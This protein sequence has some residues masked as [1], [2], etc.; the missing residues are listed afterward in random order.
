MDEEE[1][2][3]YGIREYFQ[4]KLKKYFDI[5]SFHTKDAFI[6]FA[7]ERQKEIDV[8][9]GSEELLL[10]EKKIHKVKQCI[11]LSSG[12]RAEQA[13][14]DV[15]YKYQSKECIM[16]EFLECCRFCAGTRVTGL[17]RNTKLLGVYSP[18]G[19]CGKTTLAM[20]LG[21]VL[22]EKQK[23]LYMSFEEW[24][25][26][27]RIIGEGNGMDIS[28]LIYYIKQGKKDIGMYLNGMLIDLNGL[29]IIPP[30]TKTPDIQELSEEEINGII[31]KVLINSEFDIVLVD[32][33]NCVKTLFS[34]LEPIEKIYM[35]VLKDQVS[36]A[37][38]LEFLDFLEHSKYSVY[39][40]KFKQCSFKETDYVEGE[41][42][43]ELYYGDFGTYVKELLR[44]EEFWSTEEES[45][46]Q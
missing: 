20:V 5:Y 14:T 30:V 9:L 22:A 6:K 46:T 2:Y 40:E 21:Q 42:L 3:L 38:L 41:T 33:G 4:E 37:K 17:R 36:K 24:P 34:I 11:Y 15:I 43:E 10:E 29:K 44:E 35:P 25:G 45:R 32:V 13:E 31:E 27:G 16:K 12:N 1:D 28:D 7:K 39:T 18:I 23:V 19:R 8:F 26:F